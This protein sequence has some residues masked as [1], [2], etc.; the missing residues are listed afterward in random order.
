MLSSAGHELDESSPP[1]P[2]LDE[3]SLHHLTVFLW[4]PFKYYPP[5]MLRSPKWSVSFN[6]LTEI[7]YAFIIFSMH[8]T[9]PAHCVL[10]WSSWWCFVRIT[11][12]EAFSLLSF[13]LN[14]ATSFPVQLLSLAPCSLVEDSMFFFWDK[15]TSLHFPSIVLAR[16]KSNMVI[17][18]YHTGV[19]RQNEDPCYWHSAVFQEVSWVICYVKIFV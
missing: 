7:L 10:V 9:C 13:P 18:C 19:R 3:L 15:R 11:K 6:F 1:H 17:L 5:A 2:E 8:I 14:P 4:G 12:F 16:L